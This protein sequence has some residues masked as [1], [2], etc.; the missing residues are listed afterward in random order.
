MGNYDRYAMQIR[1]SVYGKDVRN[2]VCD[3]LESASEKVDAIKDASLGE[4]NNAYLSSRDELE[5]S[6]NRGKS[7]IETAISNGRSAISGSISEKTK[8]MRS[9]ILQ[10]DM[11]LM[12]AIREGISTVEHK[13]DTRISTYQ[14]RQIQVNSSDY[15][16]IF[17]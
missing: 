3:A 13:H 15:E 6:V 11:R 8:E 7:D 9:F 2:P 17:S 4:V 16:L 14:I 10:S 1:K 12:P 5:R